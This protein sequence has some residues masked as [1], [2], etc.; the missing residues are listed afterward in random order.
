[1]LGWV[2]SGLRETNLRR[3]YMSLWFH[4]DTRW[5]VKRCSQQRYPLACFRTVLFN[6]GVLCHE[7]RAEY[8]SNN[9]CM[10]CYLGMGMAILDR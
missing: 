10:F 5:L 7:K 3:I 2:T 6:D 1:M 8:T 4:V 9:R